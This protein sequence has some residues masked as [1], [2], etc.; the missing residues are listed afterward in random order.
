MPVATSFDKRFRRAHLSASRTRPVRFRR[1][2]VALRRACL[3]ALVAY[4]G[5]RGVRLVLHAPLLHVARIAVTGNS[6]LSNGEVLAMMGGLKGEN[7]LFLDLPACRRRLLGSPWVADATV[8]RVL[9]STIEVAIVER[10]PL[11]IGRLGGELFLVDERGGV[12]EEYGPKYSELDLPII[13]GL[14][15]SSPEGEPLI[16]EARASLAARL[17]TALR[18]RPDLAKRISQ[19]DV[20][21]AHNAEVILEHDAAVVR[22][23]EGRFVERLQS[24]LELAPTLHEKVA[25][26]DY[27]DLRFGE[28]VYV[29]PSN[30][31]ALMAQG[32]QPAARKP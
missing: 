22:L 29:G 4:A 5:Y 30:G 7:I 16:D 17:L 27:V 26:I 19:I 15:G 3:A 28:R 1:P 31:S 11:G 10:H 18:A 20:S 2:W 21:D 25:A 24:Y 12:I 8:R 23:G 13:D 9:P 6:R 32:V 14:A